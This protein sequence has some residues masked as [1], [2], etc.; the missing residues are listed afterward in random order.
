MSSGTTHAVSQDGRDPMQDTV[1]HESR[2]SVDE[3]RPGA[4]LVK[5]PFGKRSG[6]A[7]QR[8][9]G[10]R[11]VGEREDGEVADRREQRRAAA[12]QGR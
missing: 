4:S 1:P 6:Q 12:F 3:R 10:K 9:P 8:H 11:A 2:R 7:T 5:R